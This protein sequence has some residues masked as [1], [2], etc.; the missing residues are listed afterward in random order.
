MSNYAIST[1]GAEAVAYTATPGTLTGYAV[2]PTLGVLVYLLTVTSNAWVAQGIADTVFT[3]NDVTFAFTATAHGLI[4]GMPVQV[5]NSGGAL[6]TGLS[7][8]TT[9][10]AAVIDANTFYLYDTRAHAL[11]GGAT[12]QVQVSSNG[13]GTQTA[14]TVAAPNTAGSAYLPLNE[15]FRIDSAL[16]AKISVVRDTASGEASLLPLVPSR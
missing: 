9:Y 2:S 5:S 15:A 8:A 10:W 4:T 1:P 13:T 3:A 14:T 11:A 7:A 12:G 16:G 6:P